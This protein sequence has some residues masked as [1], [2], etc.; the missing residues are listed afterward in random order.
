MRELEVRCCCDPGK[1]LG[2]LQLPDDQCRPGKRL[3]YHVVELPPPGLAWR[4]DAGELP[5]TNVAREVVLSVEHLA[6]AGGW[7]LA[8]KSNDYPPE[9]LQRVPGFRAAR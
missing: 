7:Y 2:Y 1:L 6:G 5:A 8:V 9:T 4:L 3:R